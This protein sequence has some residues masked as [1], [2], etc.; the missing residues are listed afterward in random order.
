MDLYGNPLGNNFSGEVT[1]D[2]GLVVSGDGTFENLTVT[3]TL[4]ATTIISEQELKIE[5]SLIELAVNNPADNLNLGLIEHFN[6]GQEKY[7]GLIRDRTTK[8]QYLYEGAMPIPTTTTDI[9]ALPRG[10]LVVQGLQVS[11]YT[12]PTSDGSQNQIISTNGSGSLTFQDSPGL[13]NL[14]SAYDES[15]EP[16]ITTDLINSSLVI[17][18]GVGVPAPILEVQDS[19]SNNIF[20]VEENLVAVRKGFFRV[21]PPTGN[22]YGRVGASGANSSVFTVGQF[23]N[24]GAACTVA[25]EISE[26]TASGTI[27]SNLSFVSGTDQFLFQNLASDGILNL[28]KNGTELVRFSEINTT[29]LNNFNVFPPSGQAD[30]NVY[31]QAGED[32]VAGFGQPDTRQSN[33]FINSNDRSLLQL[34]SETFNLVK[35]VPGTSATA[36]LYC[37]EHKEALDNLVFAYD[38]FGARKEPLKIDQDLVTTARL[39]VNG[40]YELPTIDGTAGQYLSTD[41]SGVVSWESL[42]ES[43][44]GE[45]RISN[46]LLAT[47]MTVIGQWEDIVGGR[48]AGPLKD[49]T[50]QATT[51]TYTGVDTKTFKYSFQCT[52][53]LTSGVAEIFEIGIFKNGLLAGGVMNFSMDDT[54]PFPRSTSTSIVIDLATNDTI[55]TKIRATTNVPESVDVKNMVSNC[56]SVTSGQGS[57]GGGSGTLQNAYDLSSSPEITTDLGRGLTLR[58]GGVSGFEEVLKIQSNLGTTTASITAGGLATFNILNAT[59]TSLLQGGLKLGDVNAVEDYDLPTNNIGAQ[60]G[61]ILK[62]DSATRKLQFFKPFA[63][64]RDT[65]RVISNNALELALTDTGNPDLVIPAGTLKV[66]DAYRITS[67]GQFRNNGI[68]DNATFRVRMQPLGPIVS[69]ILFGALAIGSP[70]YYKLEVLLTARTV[71][72]SASFAQTISFFVN[73]QTVA[74]STAPVS[75]FNSLVDQ[76]FAVSGQWSNIGVNNIITQQQLTIEKIS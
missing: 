24:S 4:T 19:S 21:E 64:A 46:N 55:T 6:D 28:Q 9:S 66:G 31:V 23:G 25:G 8:K 29:V 35:F 59:G 33:V 18:Q 32:V 7:S 26:F 63:Y 54:N 56:V 76:P 51:L 62:Y 5:D 53:E 1:V 34:N 72:G 73:N 68:L 40:S 42:P 14:Q 44:Y 69:Q 16:Q 57:G 12:L 71:G 45:Q 37:I 20:E 27:S 60:D 70:Q 48:T 75:T 38:P 47:S 49:F 39:S 65:A 36:K 13:Q 58:S 3:D 41:G 50:S 52:S 10:D 43:S 22:A 11:N 15:T 74:S 67:T 30:F 61:D 17:K 2:G